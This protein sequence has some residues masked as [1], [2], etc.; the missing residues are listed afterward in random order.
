MKKRRGKTLLL[1]A[2]I[3]FMVV[4]ADPISTYLA[5]EMPGFYEKNAISRWWLEHYGMP[6]LF[7]AN[8]LPFLFFILFFLF[9]YA[10]LSYAI[11]KNFQKNKNI[12]DWL[13]F[14]FFLGVFVALIVLKAEVVYNN[15]RLLLGH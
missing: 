15:V 6:G 13:V 7:L 10:V 14:L 1:V 3:S 8:L 9:G 12:A 2:V 11:N 5:L 4:L